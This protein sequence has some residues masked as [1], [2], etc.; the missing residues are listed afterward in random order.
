MVSPFLLPAVF[1][2]CL[3]RHRLCIGAALTYQT[4]LASVMLKNITGARAGRPG[5]LERARQVR[6][7]RCGRVGAV[8]LP[9]AIWVPSSAARSVFR[10]VRSRGHITVCSSWMCSRGPDEPA[11]QLF[12]L[13][14]AGP[15]QPG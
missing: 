4:W 15:L 6:R 13:R 11:E 2:F 7:V 3:A 9:S 12:E 8:F 14:V 5:R 1:S 10:A